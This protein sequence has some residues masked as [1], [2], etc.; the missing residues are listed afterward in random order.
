MPKTKNE[1]TGIKD[2]STKPKKQ[3]IEVKPK[4]PTKCG[5]FTLNEKGART[6]DEREKRWANHQKRRLHNCRLKHKPKF[7]TP[8]SF[9]M[10]KTSARWQSKF[11]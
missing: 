2:G 10:P 1:G 8:I 4:P 5:Y 11:N 9:L 3:E 7:L 6:G